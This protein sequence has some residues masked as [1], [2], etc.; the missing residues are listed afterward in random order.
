M[1]H[2]LTV[3]GIIIRDL[4]ALAEACR[5]L[6]LELVRVQT[7]HRWYGRYL[8]DYVDADATGQLRR[9]PATFGHCDHAIRSVGQPSAY[10]I[11][12]CRRTDGQG[13][14]LVYDRFMG[15]HGLEAKAGKGLARVKQE[16]A[17]AVATRILTAQR[18]Q[19]TRHVQADGRIIIQA[20]SR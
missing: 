2:V 6:G 7:T 4:D 13:Y 15:G 20:V 11:G 17:A 16:Y 1:S 9:D 18:L 12:L 3:Q 19:W 5:T 10:E 14:D 8:G